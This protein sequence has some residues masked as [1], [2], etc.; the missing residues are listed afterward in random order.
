MGSRFLVAAESGVPEGYRRR[1]SAARDTETVITR[2]VSG[3]PARGL[4]N[5]LVD[6][7]RGGRPAGARLAAP[8]RAP[9]PTCARRRAAADAPELMALWAGQAAGLAG[10][11]HPAGR[12]VQETVDE[13]VAVLRALAASTR[14]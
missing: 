13:A 14:A 5:R 2:A 7:A 10:P 12:I 4:P 6:D 8:G 3:R 11:A 1:V 9:A